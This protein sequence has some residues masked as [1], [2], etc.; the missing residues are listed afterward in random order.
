MGAWFS[1][2]GK[3]VLL[4]LSTCLEEGYLLL[5]LAPWTVQSNLQTALLSARKGQTGAGGGGGGANGANSTG[6]CV[7]SVKGPHPGIVKLGWM[8][9]NT[10]KEYN[11]QQSLCLQ[12]FDSIIQLTSWHIVYVPGNLY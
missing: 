3:E 9:N 2:V 5:S 11:K 6:P 10:G 1:Y 4:V 7:W 8:V 12:A